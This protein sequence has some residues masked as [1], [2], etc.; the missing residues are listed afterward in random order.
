MLW[1]QRDLATRA[2]FVATV[3]AVLGVLIPPFAVASALVAVGF[4]GTAV[5]R[6]RRRGETNRLGSLCLAVSGALIVVIV[7]G[8]AI[9]AAGR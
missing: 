5:I 6:A 8:S 3:L 4:A 1:H 7:V 9:Y 2:G